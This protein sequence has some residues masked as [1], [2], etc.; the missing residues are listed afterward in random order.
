[1]PFSKLVFCVLQESNSQIKI[2]NFPAFYQGI[3]QILAIAWMDEWHTI[4]FNNDARLDVCLP[5]ESCFT[6]KHVPCVLSLDFS[7][8]F[9]EA[10]AR[11]QIKHEDEENAVVF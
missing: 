9:Y 2:L 7:R 3:Y 8:G 4:P 5:N 11:V 6:V 10:R 1:M